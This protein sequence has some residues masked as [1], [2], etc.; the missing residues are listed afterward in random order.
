ML[1]LRLLDSLLSLSLYLSLSLCSEFQRL[2]EKRRDRDSFIENKRRK[3]RTR[4][5]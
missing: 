3:K 2:R 4:E 1:S 5:K